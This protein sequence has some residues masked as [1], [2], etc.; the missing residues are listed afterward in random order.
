MVKIHILWEVPLSSRISRLEKANKKSFRCSHLWVQLWCNW[1]ALACLGWNPFLLYLSLANSCFSSPLR[2]F[3]DQE[4]FS[5]IHT[6]VL[7]SLHLQTMISVSLL[8]GWLWACIKVLTD[9]W[10]WMPTLKHYPLL[11]QELLPFSGDFTLP[12]LVLV[13]SL[14]S[15]E[16]KDMKW[17]GTRWTVTKKQMKA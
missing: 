16:E 15:P 10:L 3:K 1:G 4:S 14:T 9:I 17:Q 2:V 6:T 8:V 13:M 11:K 5:F 12:N 7:L